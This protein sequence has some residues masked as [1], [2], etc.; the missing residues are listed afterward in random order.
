MEQG[1]TLELLEEIR[2]QNQKNLM[3]QRVSTALMLIF[4]VILLLLVPN[5]VSTLHIASDTLKNANEAVLHANDA[6]TQ[7]EGTL[8][9][10]QTLVTSSGSG[11]EEAISKMNSIDIETLN[12]AI[13]DLSEVVQPMAD[14]FG[15]FR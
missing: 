5:V 1:T 11:M 7:M 6:I 4:V 13:Q 9:S 2:K 8:D 15:R 3:Y 10:I 12:D 14:F